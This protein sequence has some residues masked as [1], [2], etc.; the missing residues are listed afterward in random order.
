MNDRQFVKELELSDI[1]YYWAKFEDLL[2]WAKKFDED[3]TEY[4]KLIVA[5]FKMMD[6][7]EECLSAKH[8]GDKNE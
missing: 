6:R 2:A 8:F 3:S 7:F 1:E 5:A 4:T